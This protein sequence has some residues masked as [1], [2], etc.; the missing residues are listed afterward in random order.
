MPTHEVVNTPPLWRDVNLFRADQALAGRVGADHAALNR[1]G[2]L[3]G[4]ERAQ[5]WGRVANAVSPVLHTHDRYGH[6]I[7]EVEFHPAWHELMSVAVGAGLHA[8]PWRADTP[9]AHVARA[10]GF[11]VWGQVEAGHG[12]PISMTYAVVPALRHSPEL[13]ST[14]E[15][16][17]TSTSYD[18]G[19]RAP[20]T[21]SGLL[22]GM[23]MTEKQ[24]GSDVRANRTTAQPNADGSYTLTGHKW[25]CSAPMCDLFLVLA[26]ASQGL[27]CFLV[28]RVLPDGNRNP[29]LLQRLKDKLGNR[30][31]ASSEV[32]FDD[33]T[34]WLV[35]EE[36]R[37]VRTIIDMVTM[38]RLDC[39]IGSAATQRAALTQAMHHARHRSTFGA[40]LISQPLMREVLADLAVESE[41]ATALFVRLAHAVDNNEKAFLRLAVAVGKY[42]VC[43]R[44][45]TVVGEALEC[46][47][48]NGY[49][50]ESGLP[51]LFRESPLNSIWE[52][53]GNV[54]ALDVVR[55]AGRDE[56]SVGALGDELNTTAGADPDLDA[57]VVGVRDAMR[58]VASD[59]ALGQ[60]QARSIAGLLARCL[61][62][63]LLIR[64]APDAVA[65]GFIA[66]RI[67]QPPAAVAGER[68]GLI[69]VDA[70]LDRAAVA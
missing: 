8:A 20:Q 34:A 6:R 37:G 51:R 4:T 40:P 44:T 17:L 42:W 66:T 15:P 52:G 3:A 18:F 45:P 35:G 28:P 41:A 50:E 1:L 29:F 54:I 57:A 47:G 62:A 26:Q 21:K 22:A 2:E 23:A 12:C 27:S 53:S 60:Q 33:T 67:A 39:V 36:G 19:L 5:E 13:A 59:P 10:A 70:M 55:A 63:S 25:F 30:S 14:Y 16:L 49:V 31:N 61:Q 68:A 64:T 46:L 11:F 48:G 9:G 38:T 65:R 32:E 56:A 69:D 58:A 43:K 7:D 24:G